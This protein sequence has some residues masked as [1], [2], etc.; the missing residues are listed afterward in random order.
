MFNAVSLDDVALRF[1]ILGGAVEGGSR[2]Q[3]NTDNQKQEG[4]SEKSSSHKNTRTVL[5]PLG[6][7]T[8]TNRKIIGRHAYRDAVQR[9]IAGADTTVSEE[10]YVPYRV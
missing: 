2:R 5:D 1:G 4:I 7:R 8:L 6:A 10:T 9:Q 3:A